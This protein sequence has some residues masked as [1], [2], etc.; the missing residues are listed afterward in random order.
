MRRFLMIRRQ[1]DVEVV[2]INVIV[3]L[4]MKAET[5]FRCN[6]I[7]LYFSS[8]CVGLI[9][10]YVLQLLT[11]WIDSLISVLRCYFKVVCSP[12]KIQSPS[13]LGKCLPFFINYIACFCATYYTYGILP[14][15]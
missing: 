15:Q 1:L 4:R 8:F 2:N 14:P 11:T 12:W 9:G 10:H 3:G 13:F 7:R 5:C 6:Q